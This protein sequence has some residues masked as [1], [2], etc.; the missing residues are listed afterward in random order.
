MIQ[1]ERD[2]GACKRKPGSRYLSESYQSFRATMPESRLQL[3]FYHHQQPCT[4]ITSAIASRQIC[5][6]LSI[7]PGT[8]N[9]II[10]IRRTLYLVKR[11]SHGCFILK[12]WYLFDDLCTPKCGKQLLFNIGYTY[13]LT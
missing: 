7:R 1:L 4:C 3:F 8:Q 2:W 12:F 10:P 11:L 6:I 9:R 5:F 13:L